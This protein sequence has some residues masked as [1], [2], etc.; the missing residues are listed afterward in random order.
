MSVG[1]GT[2]AAEAVRKFAALVDSSG[3]LKKLEI[4]TG[5]LKGPLK[6]CREKLATLER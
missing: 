6:V 5:V 1:G 4:A 2:A 3:V